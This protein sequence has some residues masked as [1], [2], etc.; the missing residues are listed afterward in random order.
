MIR[1]KIFIFVYGFAF[2]LGGTPVIHAQASF[3]SNTVEL[4]YLQ[5]ASYVLGDIQ[6]VGN[7]YVDTEVLLA[8]TTLQVGDT[9]TI[10]SDTMQNA[11]K[12]LWQQRFIKSVAFYASKM[13]DNQLRLFIY[14]EENP[15]LSTCIFEGGTK[16]DEEKLEKK[17]EISRGKVITPRFLK[18]AKYVAEKYYT[19]Q[20]FKDARVEVTTLPDPTD[21]TYIQLKFVINKGEKCIINKIIF[22]GNNHISSDVLRAQLEYLHEKPRFTLIKDILY[23]TI[24]LQ[25]ARKGGIFWNKPTWDQ[26]MVYLKNHCIFFSSKFRKSHY[27]EDKKRILAYYQSQGY[28]DVKIIRERSYKVRKDRLNLEITLEEGYPYYV[29]NINWVGNHLHSAN[30]LQKILGIKKGAIYSTTLLEERL[31]ANPRGFDVRSLYMN[32]GYL[33]FDVNPIIV[34]I[35][36]DQVDLEIRVR[37][38]EQYSFN[39]VN[40]LGNVYTHDYV[41]RRELRTLPGDLFSKANVSRSYRELSMLNIFDKNI[42]I[43]PFPD[44]ETNTVDIDYTV[45]EA[46]KFD[47]K[48]TASLVGLTQLTLGTELGT[49]NFSM[50]NL[51]RGKIPIGDAQ[52]FHIKAEFVGL[53]QQNF[54]L[55]FVEPYLLGSPNLLDV[56]VSQFFQQYHQGSSLSHFSTHSALSRRLKWPDDY[57]I[58]K[59]GYKYRWYNYRNYKVLEDLEENS[60]IILTGTTHEVALELGIERNST[61]YSIYPKKGSIIS[62]DSQLTPPYSWFTNQDHIT[63]QELLKRKEYIQTTVMFEYFYNFFDD[64]VINLFARGGG[65]ATYSKRIGP[66][67]RFIMG[68]TGM[69]YPSLLGQET[70][71]LRGYPDYFIRPVGSKKFYQGGVLFDKFGAELRYPIIQA[72][73][74]LLLYILLFAEAGNTW[75]YYKDWRFLDLKKSAGVGMRFHMIIGTIGLDWGYGFDKKTPDKL[76]VHFRLGTGIH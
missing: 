73:G 11:M 21:A 48:A 57:Y 16:T 14:I 15:R 32:D 35:E 28:K 52:S 5:P 6:V 76:E 36:N 47:I 42:Q 9:I 45:K 22:K 67:S 38:G 20:G 1:K 46:P 2:L 26:T 69:A 13:A 41:I 3:T 25:P 34:G 10:P 23:K 29:R 51:I 17:L 31:N 63:I 37:E 50:G 71:G 18:N 30:K 43:N 49:N 24:T 54:S 55:Q 59:I 4:N 61:D 12:K 8:V 72:G 53:E 66:F 56:S 65:L 60:N 40:I 74:G 64:W 62:L 19:K 68:G 70:I 7:T 44:P 75:A 27:K 33:L 58:A 39:M